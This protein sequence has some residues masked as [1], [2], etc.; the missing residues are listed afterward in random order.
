MILR[1]FE[2]ISGLRVNFLK[3]KVYGINLNDSFLQAASSFFSCSVD[4]I[5][6][7]QILGANLRR[8]S[9]WVQVVENLK[10]RLASWKGK[11]LSIGGR[12]TL[13]NAVLNSIPLYFLS[14]FKAPKKVIQYITSIQ[15]NFLWSGCSEDKKICWVSWDKICKRKE[16]GGLGIKEVEAFNLALLNKWK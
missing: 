9:T 4:S 1:S 8:C 14:F 7:F 5:H 16:E 10:K 6:T 12:V 13:I 15:R 2:L 3:S 11:Q